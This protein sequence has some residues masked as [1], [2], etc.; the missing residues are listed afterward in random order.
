MKKTILRTLFTISALDVVLGVVLASYA[1]FS[2]G[3]PRIW[4][5]ALLLLCCGALGVF[6]FGSALRRQSLEART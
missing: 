2:V 4:R 5:G 1:L 6:W 3:T